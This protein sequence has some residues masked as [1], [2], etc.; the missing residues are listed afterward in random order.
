MILSAQS[1]PYTAPSRT[2]SSPSHKTHTK[3]R[4]QQQECGEQAFGIIMTIVDV[5]VM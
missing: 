2:D 3:L 5:C 4:K 1:A